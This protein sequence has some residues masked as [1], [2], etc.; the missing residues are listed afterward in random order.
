MV[1]AEGR[2][3]EQGANLPVSTY[4]CIARR[5]LRLFE[6]RPRARDRCLGVAARALGLSL[7][8]WP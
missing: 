8:P 1:F 5:R 2:I 3:G 7:R 4:Q 6:R